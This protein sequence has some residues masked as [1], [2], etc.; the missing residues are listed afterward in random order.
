MPATPTGHDRTPT[1]TSPARRRAAYR[2]W[3]GSDRCTRPGRSSRAAVS[4]WP[5]P[6][7]SPPPVV[8]ASGVTRRLDPADPLPARHR[9]STNASSSSGS[10]PSPTVTVAKPRIAPLPSAPVTATRVRPWTTPSPVNW[11][12]S[13]RASNSGASPGFDREADR[14]IRW[15]S[16]RSAGTAVRMVLTGSSTP[17]N[18]GRPI[19][20]RARQGGDCTDPLAAT[21]SWQLQGKPRSPRR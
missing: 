21:D 19:P 4:R 3:R 18:R 5:T 6:R 10:P 20:R 13:G 14:K 12:N 15:S 16:G 7:C 1:T 17:L 8:A 9:G 11:R 2:S